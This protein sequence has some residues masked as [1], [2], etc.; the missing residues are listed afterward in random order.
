MRQ[1]KVAK[2]HDRSALLGKTDSFDLL[3]RKQGHEVSQRRGRG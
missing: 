1:E 3:A 2:T